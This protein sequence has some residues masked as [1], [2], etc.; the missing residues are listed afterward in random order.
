MFKN[1]AEFVICSLL[2]VAI[3]A[4]ICWMTGEAIERE[5]RLAEKIFTG[6]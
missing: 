2:L 4:G 6:R 3:V 1:K 5:A